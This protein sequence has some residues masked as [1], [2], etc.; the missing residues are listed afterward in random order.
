MSTVMINSCGF[1]HLVLV[2]HGI[3]PMVLHVVEA[4]KRL[5]YSPL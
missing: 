4:L 2:T 5:V 3:E 1:E